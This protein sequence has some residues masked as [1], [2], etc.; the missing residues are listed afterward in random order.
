[1]AQ[2][3]WSFCCWKPGTR[4]RLWSLRRAG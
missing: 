1:M 3:P 2:L 4:M